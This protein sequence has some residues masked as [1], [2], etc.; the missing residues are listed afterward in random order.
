[1]IAIA[2]V[3]VAA[4]LL[5]ERLVRYFPTLGATDMLV[6]IMLAIS[7]PRTSARAE[8]SVLW[9]ACFSFNRH[10]AASSGIPNV[11]RNRSSHGFGVLQSIIVNTTSVIP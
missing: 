5:F 7:K 11:F 1:M 10:Y 2:L 8:H 4:K 6:P 3:T 9:I